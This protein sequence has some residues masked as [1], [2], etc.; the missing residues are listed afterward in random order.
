MRLDAGELCLFLDVDGTLL[1][2]LDAPEQVVA[3]DELQTLLH[4]AGR[5]TSGATAL[6]SGRSIAQIDRMFA[7]GE[8]P[9]AGLH[10]LERRDAQ[11]RLHRFRLDHSLVANARSALE[12]IACRHPHVHVEDK[13]IAIALHFR[14]SPELH[15]TLAA[16]VQAIADELGANYHVQPGSCVLEIKPVGATK[17]DAMDAFLAEPPFA[18]RRPVFA[19]DDLTDLGAFE[20]VERAGGLS[21][22]VGGRVHAMLNFPTVLH[23][24]RFLAGLVEP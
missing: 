18:G 6:I 12:R 20:T 8:W 22:A 16:E 2:F 7:P 1:E 24:R 15:S 23:F 10:G 17:A 9:A 5:A 4:G 3:D 11:G 13:G 14:R 21:I 19:G